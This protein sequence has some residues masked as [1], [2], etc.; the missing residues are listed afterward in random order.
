[1]VTFTHKISDP[2]GLHAIN[3]ARFAMFCRE[4]PCV[5]H[6]AR[7]DMAADGRQ[8]MGLMK[9]RAKRGGGFGVQSGWG[10]RRRGG[11]RAERIGGGTFV[12]EESSP[13]P[14]S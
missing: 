1:M 2:K 11:R 9:L 4:C 12:D 13:F 7:R 6:V 14:S 5:V 3:A 10:W 8:M